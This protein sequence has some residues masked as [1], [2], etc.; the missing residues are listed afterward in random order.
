MQSGETDRVRSSGCAGLVGP[1]G[2]RTCARLDYPL[3]ILFLSDQLCPGVSGESEAETLRR[4]ERS[5]LLEKAGLLYAGIHFLVWSGSGAPICNISSHLSKVLVDIV[6]PPS[7]LT[8]EKIEELRVAREYRLQK[9]RRAL[10]AAAPMGLALRIVDRVCIEQAPLAGPAAIQAPLK[11]LRAGLSALVDAL[12]LDSKA[13]QPSAAPSSQFEATAAEPDPPPRR[14]RK[15]R[16]ETRFNPD[17]PERPDRA[18]VRK[19]IHRLKTLGTRAANCPGRRLRDCGERKMLQSVKV[20]GWLIVE[21]TPESARKSRDRSS[22][23]ALPI[24][25]PKKARALIAYLA[26]HKAAVSRDKLADLLWPYQ[27]SEQAR[28]SLRNC[29]CEARKSV[30]PD[31]IGSNF[32]HCRVE[33]PTDLDEFRLLARSNDVGDWQAALELYRGDF[34]DG[35]FINSESWEEW[36]AYTRDELRELAVNT[37]TR[38]AEAYLV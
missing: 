38:L 21:G 6:G 8:P 27:H 31:A 20:L 23:L 9:C 11:H 26:M 34:L 13:R 32:T 4:K 7:E 30:G 24:K 36:V 18:E 14:A 12:D 22:N 1:R 25:L 15:A 35:L 33:T 17:L 29:L 3:G 37:A 5:V 28:H 16:L 2:V 10:A 19:A